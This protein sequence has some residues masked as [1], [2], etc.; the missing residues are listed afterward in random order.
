MAYLSAYLLRFE[1]TISHGN[2]Q[3]IVKSLPLIILVQLGAFYYFGLYKKIWR[4]IGLSDVISI[5]KAVTLGTVVSVV[6][7][8]LT[9]R[10]I[11]FSRA[12]FVIYWMTLIVLVTGVRGTL[13]LLREYFAE[14]QKTKGKRV[15]IFGAGDAGTAL[16]REIKNN[17]EL[18]YRVI[19]FIDDDLTKVGRKI[20]GKTVLGSGKDI[21]RV[22]KDKGIEEILIAISSLSEENLQRITDMCQESGLPYRRM[23]FKIKD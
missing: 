19:G 15:L 17:P 16:L 1:G 23:V 12:V 10:F 13:R 21:L 5:V 22:A 4:Y 20:Y 2:L 6:I 7:L 11:G 18:H 9:T 8:V 3:L 14:I